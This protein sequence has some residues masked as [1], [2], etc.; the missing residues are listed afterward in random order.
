MWKFS[1]AAA[2][3]SLH[4]FSFLVFFFYF[5]W[6]VSGFF[7]FV[8]IIVVGALSAVPSLCFTFVAWPKIISRVFPSSSSAFNKWFSLYKKK[9]LWNKWIYRNKRWTNDLEMSHDLLLYQCSSWLLVVYLVV[10]SADGYRSP[11]SNSSSIR[12]P[13][14]I[15]NLWPKKK[16]KNILNWIINI[17]QPR[18][19]ISFQLQAKIRSSSFSLLLLLLRFDITRLIFCVK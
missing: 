9:N 10:V 1:V 2:F 16:T 6:F 11:K 14:C 18:A 15:C 4:L 13:N 5:S 17:H 12:F 3:H 8:I 7:I 19:G